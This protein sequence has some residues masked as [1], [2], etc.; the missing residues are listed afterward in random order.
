MIAREHD[1]RVIGEA[2]FVERIEHT[3]NLGIQ[4]TDARE[5]RLQRL[6]PLVVGHPIL[7]R[8]AAAERRLRHVFLI[9]SHARDEPHL[10][11]GVQLEVGRLRGDVR[12]VRPV[13]PDG[14]E[15]RP[16]A[17]TGA[18]FEHPGRIVGHDAV[19]MRTVALR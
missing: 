17:V 5:I 12:R 10:G 15:K 16:R 1:D 8:V 7:L 13:E 14:E 4:K 6:P 11:L 3:T 18:A 9:L 19:G 2:L